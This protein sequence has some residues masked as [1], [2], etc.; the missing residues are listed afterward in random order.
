MNNESI[1]KKSSLQL[2]DDF[3]RPWHK[4][5]KEIAFRK[6]DQTYSLLKIYV[7][8]SSF[9]LICSLSKSSSFL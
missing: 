8:L 6:A 2:P 9:L 4:L 5:A 7:M 1:A 3:Y